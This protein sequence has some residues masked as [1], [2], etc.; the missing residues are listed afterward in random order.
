MCTHFSSCFILCVEYSAI[1]QF[2][3]FCLVPCPLWS[4]SLYL[5]TRLTVLPVFQVFICF[6][7]MPFPSTT[8]VSV[9]W[10]CCH[11][12]CWICYVLIISIFVSQFEHSNFP[13]LAVSHVTLS[14]LWLANSW[15]MSFLDLHAKRHHKDAQRMHKDKLVSPVHMPFFTGVSDNTCHI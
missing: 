1:D 6:L 11:L 15:S 12:L 4:I 13:V 7:C 9:I 2:S 5:E 14:W 10:D 3:P 8:L